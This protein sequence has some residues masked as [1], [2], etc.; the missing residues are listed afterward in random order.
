MSYQSLAN[1]KAAPFLTFFCCVFF[2][3]GVAGLAYESVWTHYVKLFVGHASYAQSLVIAIFMGGMALGSWLCSFVIHKISKPL[4]GYVLVEC[5]I[6]AY[7]FAFDGLSQILLQGSLSSDA[8]LTS[9]IGIKYGLWSSAIILL[10]PGAIL[11]GTTFPLFAAALLNVLPM[12]SGMILAVIYGSNSLG[13]AFGVLLNGIWTVP[14]FGLPGALLFAA[15]INVLIALVLYVFSKLPAFVRLQAEQKLPSSVE[16]T[17][18]QNTLAEN[19]IGSTHSQ[20]PQSLIKPLMLVAAGTGMASFIYEIL[21]LRG[22]SL[23]MGAATISFELMLS[24]FILGLAIGGFWIRKHLDQAA[25]QQ[26]Y[27]LA[28]IQVAMGCFA[29]LTAWAFTY[30]F[31]FIAELGQ[32]LSRSHNGYFLYLVFSYVLAILVM[33]PTTICAG[34]TLPLITNLMFK[35]RGQSYVG[36]VYALN[37]LG[38]ILGVVIALNWIMPLLGIQWGLAVG[39]LVDI[40]LGLGLFYL[41]KPFLTFKKTYVLI[42]SMMLF[43]LMVLPHYDKKVHSSVFR[44]FDIYNPDQV[45]TLFYQDGKTASISVLKVLKTGNISLASNG[46]VDASASADVNK[47]HQGDMPTQVLSGILPYVYHS[48]LKRAAVIGLGS[49]ISSHTLLSSDKLE[50]LYTVEIEPAVVEGAR[51]FKS[52][53]AHLYEDPRSE[54]VVEDGKVFFASLKEPLDA[55]ISEPSNPW[56]SGTASLFTQEFYQKV[57]S[58]LNEDGVMVQWLQTYEFNDALLASILNAIA[59]HFEEINVHYLGSDALVVASQIPLSPNYDRIFAEPAFKQRLPQIGYGGPND[60]A[61]TLTVNTSGLSLLA[62]QFSTRNSD[63]FPVVDFLAP[64]ARFLGQK[65]QFFNDYLQNYTDHD[66]YDWWFTQNDERVQSDTFYS[67]LILEARQLSDAWL[68]PEI[69]ALTAYGHEQKTYRNLCLKDK[70]SRQEALSLLRVFT[71]AL[72]YLHEQEVTQLVKTVQQAACFVEDARVQR[73]LTSMALA[74]TQQV[75]QL[76]EILKQEAIEAIEDPLDELFVML[77]IQRT[78]LRL[79]DQA[80]EGWEP[81]QLN[82]TQVKFHKLTYKKNDRGPFNFVIQ[83]P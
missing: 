83:T 66:H 50:K 73:L 79:F 45:E 17:D 32:G 27:L 29:M 12:K 52:W 35:E 81:Q 64:K 44:S 26:V 58:V 18:Y 7:A 8:W 22:L 51:I 19:E 76:A 42:P 11:L 30:S 62:S 15:N 71:H 14:N 75:Q 21:W 31:D 60:V 34:M 48:N 69:A 55:V 78:P 20:P 9:L 37:T 3:S 40:G 70:L 72:S 74:R 2:L 4:I 56:V 13:A 16:E 82:K 1:N 77:G 61:M 54:I 80:V 47:H 49:G 36:K 33:L 41:V 68:K 59:L 53:N 24:A 65:A 67:T 57:K 46:K 28:K 5:A 6:A 39:A 43:I 25:N 63:Y 38:S 23:A 10:L